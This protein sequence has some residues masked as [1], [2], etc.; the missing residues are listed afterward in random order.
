MSVALDTEQRRTEGLEDLDSA[1][2]SV[3]IARART[4]TPLAPRRADS[5]QKI[6]LRVGRRWKI[7]TGFSRPD[8][9]A[10]R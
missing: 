2:R 4:F 3:E 5:A 6:D 8:L 7:E 9:R 1:E 10:I